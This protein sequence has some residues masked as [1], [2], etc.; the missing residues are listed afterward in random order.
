MAGELEDVK[1][2]RDYTKLVW[3]GIGVA[4]VLVLG[5]LSFSTRVSTASTQVAA[6]HILITFDVADPASRQRA[7]DTV[8]SLRERLVKGEDFAKLAEQYSGDPGSGARGG[9]LGWA[10]KGTYE[11]NFEQYVWS[12]PIGEVSPIVQTSFGYH[13]IV[14]TDRKLSQADQYDRKLEDTVKQQG[15]AIEIPDLKSLPPAAPAT[16]Q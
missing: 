14:V 9:Y 13:L 8:T 3:G 2:Y 7:L 12:A 10:D 16:A 11:G 5:A 15:P 4:I 6:K 1:D